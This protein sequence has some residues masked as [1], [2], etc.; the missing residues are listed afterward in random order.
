MSRSVSPIPTNVPVSSG[1]QVVTPMYT[2]AAVTAGDYI[3]LSGT[4]AMGSRGATVGLGLDS[5]YI[6]GTTQYGY[7]QTGVSTA[8]ASYSPLYTQGTYTGTTVTGGQLG[9]TTTVLSSAYIA[10]PGLAVLNNTNVVLIW[11]ESTSVY[12]AIY[13]NTG[14]TV[15]ARTYHGTSNSSSNGISVAGL[16]NGGFVITST[17][18]SPGLKFVTYNSAGTAQLSGTITATAYDNS[19][20]GG[21][22]DGSFFVAA[23]NNSAQL[24]FWVV[25]NGVVGTQRTATGA[26]TVTNAGLSVAGLTNGNIVLCFVA[27]GAAYFSV[28]TP[29]G[30]IVGSQTLFASA[31]SNNFTSVCATS[32]GFAMAVA[33]S[34][35]GNVYMRDFSGS[36]ITSKLCYNGTGHT[37]AVVCS[38]VNNKLYVLCPGG[39]N[40]VQLSIVTNANS[41]ATAAVTINTI[42]SVTNIYY[43]VNAVNALNNTLFIAYPVT[44]SYFLTFAPVNI[45]SLTQNVTTLTG[46]N[47]TPATNYYFLGVAA[48]SAAAGGTISVVTNGNVT[49]PS[50]YPSVTPSISFD[51][52]NG[53]SPF[54]QRGTITGRTIALKGLE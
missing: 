43:P 31:P 14:A 45:N 28:W 47:Y 19:A 46:A 26:G 3:Y 54:A 40:A 48:S 35:Q 44:V 42:S 49:L 25:T 34:G 39:S 12:Y 2:D 1:T 27:A 9:A 5:T 41:A 23:H 4:G 13:S 32:F 17:A 36:A 50:T 22:P 21:L 24:F 11:I 51:Y 53:A 15:L 18:A 33:A 7:T 37:G 38:G 6:A 52:Q 10:K 29:A 20:V 30:V 8:S 16:T